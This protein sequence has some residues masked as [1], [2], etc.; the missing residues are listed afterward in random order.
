[1]SDNEFPREIAAAVRRIAK[2]FPAVVVTGARQTGKTTLLTKL[3]GD[4]S[5]VS[6]DLPAEAQLAEEDPQS[7]LA[8]HPAPLLV[9]EVQYAP[10]LFRYLKVEI[11]RNREM[12]GRF[13][14]TGSQ[15][16]SLMQGV[17]E[18]LAG[19]CGVLELEGLTIRELGPVFSQLEESEGIAGILGRG[20]MPQLWKDTAIRP[21][22]YFSSYQ[23]TYLERDVRQLLNVSSLRDFDR[24]MRALALRSGQLLNK[25][26]LAKE[27]GI[28]SKTADKWLSVLV[29]SNQVTLLEP[30]FVNLGKRLV[31]T[32]KLFFNDVGL[33]C[34]LLGLSGQAVTGSYLV[35]AIWETVVFGELRK[36]LS[37]SAPQATIWHYRDQSRETDFI[38]EKDG[39]LHLAEAKWKEIPTSRDFA[40]M[41]KVHELLGERVEWPVMVLC[42]T[43]QSF[44]VAENL[45]AVNAFR[46]PEHLK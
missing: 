17:S 33:L 40:Q 46:L 38:I 22:D 10:K 32:P 6:L 34:F 37:L 15:K 28:N 42:R 27:T 29:A 5:Y 7:F 45:L 35:G 16:F 19:R 13:I 30:W 2:H 20:F 26:E 8:R 25:S 23:A 4:Y 41:L 18:S 36:H 24:F 31:K 44:P 14:L 11:D 39:R 1:M 3:F 21:V 12:N 9:D 43:R